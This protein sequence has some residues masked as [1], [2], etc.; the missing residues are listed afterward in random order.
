M[1]LNDLVQRRLRDRGPVRVGLIGAGKFGSMFLSQVPTT[2]GL[3]VSVI[4][5]LDAQRA[6]DVCGAVGWDGER[7]ART[8]F[9]DDGAELIACDEVDV[10]VEATGHPPAG[11]RH[12]RRA[13]REGK[14]I[15]MVNVEA[16]VLAGPLLAR[17]AA[18][19]GVVYSMAYGDQPA[20]TCELVDWGR[21]CGFEIVAAGKGTRYL[22]VYHA[23]T[24]ATVWDYYGLS[25]AQA[26]AARMNSQMFN[27]FLDGTKSGI[28]MAAIA[29]AAGLAPPPD[30]LMFPPCGVDDLPHV[31]R[32]A[33][34]GGLLHHKGQVEVVSSVERDGRPVFRDLRWGVYV[35]FE[36]P[37]AYA[38]D[39]FRQYG[40]VTD[41]S[42]RYAAM[43][44][45]LSPDRP[46]VERLHLFGRP[47]PGT[48]GLHDGLSRRRRG[49]RETA[50]A[51]GRET[52]RR[53]RLHRV[54]QADDGGRQPGPRRRA[55]RSGRRHGSAARGGRRLADWLAGRGAAGDLRGARSPAGHGT[56]FP[57]GVGPVASA[58]RGDLVKVLVTGG[59]GG[60]APAWRC[61]IIQAA[62]EAAP[63]ADAA[64]GRPSHFPNPSC[65]ELTMRGRP[66]RT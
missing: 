63:L 34:A 37:T 66:R 44:K 18:A 32:P 50:A 17:E 55:D 29:N 61:R 2:A 56:R 7:L 38:A 28:E 15:V 23:S 21:L 53:G 65:E 19:A 54:G 46:G 22:P 58:G 59:A 35:V 16:D 36:A 13:V 4:A 10:V 51:G 25:A 33:G 24:P 49:H 12:A 11:V 27:S 48:D 26:E 41:D 30:G 42:G 20:L 62:C 47:A 52:G 43:Y 39:C 45:P 5:D 64:G 57:G 8:R 40:L 31:L 14:D 1:S 3:E 9:V 6:R 60:C